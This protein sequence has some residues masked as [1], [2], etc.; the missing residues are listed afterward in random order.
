MAA[1]QKEQTV[2]SRAALCVAIMM[3]A[4]SLF[5]ACHREIR[6]VGAFPA[7]RSGIAVSLQPN[8]L[9]AAQGLARVQ[10]ALVERGLLEPSHASGHLDGRTRDALVAFQSSKQLAQT[11]LPNYRTVRALGLPPDEVF[12][13]HDPIA[14]AGP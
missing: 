4:A 5:T 11:G 12:R 2:A 3:A 10:A 7:D 9:F 14:A 8:Q 13:D 1:T 6:R